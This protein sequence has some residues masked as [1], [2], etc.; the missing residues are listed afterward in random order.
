MY[1]W[2]FFF[3]ADFIIVVIFYKKFMTQFP[4]LCI[5]D[6]N[7]GFCTTLLQLTPDLLKLSIDGANN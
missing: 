1:S 5:S 7:K 2:F 4:D 6:S 3:S